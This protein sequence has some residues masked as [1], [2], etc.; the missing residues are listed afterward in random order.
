MATSI[1]DLVLRISA[2]T[3]SL[4][5]EM[6]KVERKTEQTGKRASKSVSKIQK[7]LDGVSKAAKRAGVALVA[8]FAGGAALRGIRQAFSAMNDLATAADGLG[9][10]IETLQ[11]FEFAFIAAGSSAD[12]ARDAIKTFAEK[13]GEARVG[14]GEFVNLVKQYD[15]SLQNANG[16]MKTTE[17]MLVE[18][19]DLLA[20]MSDGAERATFGNKAFGGSWDDVVAVLNDGSQALRDVR[21]EA[22]DTGAVMSGELVRAAADADAQFNLL[23][24]RL[25]NVGKNLSIIL[26]Q[27]LGLVD[28]T[29]TQQLNRAR[30]RLEVRLAEFELIADDPSGPS[31]ARRVEEIIELEDEIVRLEGLLDKSAEAA[32]RFGNSMANAGV[33]AGEFAD[34]LV[35]LKDR[36]KDLQT[37]FA[38][39]DIVGMMGI[40]EG[41]KELDKLVAG[42]SKKTVEMSDVAQDSL[43]LIADAF[44]DIIF[45]IGNA[46][47]A[48]KNLIR[49]F[50]QL[51]IRE[52]ALAGAR[53]VV[54]FL[55]FAEGGVMTS[56]GA[57]PL[58]KYASGGVARTP[59]V[60]MFGEGTRPE[61][62]VPLPD[63][64]SIP[65]TVKGDGAGGSTI[66]NQNI[67]LAADIKNTV[68]AEI[69]GIVPALME[70]GRLANEATARGIR[71]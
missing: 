30:Q 49:S 20:D 61:A 34:R 55:P 44:E 13:V 16:T 1:E 53:K 63:G 18:V 14:T 60:A 26:G 67:T 29:T 48:V 39:G 50:G 22:R 4:S 25:G 21:Q 35:E 37:V 31:T 56:H 24:V 38:E 68:R 3:E 71:G 11:E 9:V 36:R 65:V 46:D 42:L 28:Q 62:F 5:R 27:T 6:K 10:S 17:Q 51:I 40:E 57:A 15:I 43:F 69:L 2:N 70:A 12:K 33:D 8:A 32:G 64:R 54:G 47:E 52:A 7:S 66:I 45:D 58:K 59:Q 41:I 19:A 23:A